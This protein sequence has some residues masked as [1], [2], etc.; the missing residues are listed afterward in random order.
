MAG[1]KGRSGRP[2]LYTE[3][4]AAEVCLRL[5]EG[6][7]LREICRSDHVP[8]DR[9]VRGWAAE[10]VENFFPRYVQAR[11]MGYAARADLL[12]EWAVTPQRSVERTIT[13]PDGSVE[14]FYGRDNV[15]RARL[16]VDTEKWLLSKLD[17]T[18]YGDKQTL[19]HEGFP[20]SFI[21]RIER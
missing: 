10:N 2:S 11:T 8:N 9:T 13:H 14:T 20:N 1:K 19:A 18:V 16:A 3:E 12:R 4:I 6:E 15:E 7:T 17:P 21:L 5:R